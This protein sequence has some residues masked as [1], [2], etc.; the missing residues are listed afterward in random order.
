MIGPHT[1]KHLDEDSKF[2]VSLNL[3]NVV[4]QVSSMNYGV[5]RFLSHLVDVRRKE[6]QERI[7]SYISG[8]NLETAR[9]ITLE[10]DKL[11]DGIEKLLNEGLF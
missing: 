6:H 4:I 1:Y 2:T 9:Y 7:N 5:Q 11:A 8:G 10:G 3:K